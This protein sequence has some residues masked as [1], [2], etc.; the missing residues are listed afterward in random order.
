MLARSMRRRGRTDTSALVSDSEEL[1][2]ERSGEPGN[3]WRLDKNG[4]E[5]DESSLGQDREL[6]DAWMADAQGSEDDDFVEGHRGPGGRSELL[7][8]L[9]ALPARLWPASRRRVIVVLAVAVVALGTLIGPRFTADQGGDLSAGGVAPSTTIPSV[10]TPTLIAAPATE[11]LGAATAATKLS[12]PDLPQAEGDSSTAT[13]SSD[14]ETGATSSEGSLESGDEK[15][16]GSNPG[17]QAE[18]SSSLI[19]PS[20]AFYFDFGCGLNIKIILRLPVRSYG[21]RFVNKN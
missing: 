18:D 8:R 6:S 15:S 2:Q 21:H 14:D 1:D 10:Q 11:G 9:L 20:R 13:G 19:I 16:S 3:P 7:Q 12:P 4:L 17:A 5:A